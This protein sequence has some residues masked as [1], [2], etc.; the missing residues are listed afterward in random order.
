MNLVSAVLITKNE[1]V[2]LERCLASLAWADEIV[3]LDS[4]SDDATQETAKSLGATVYE[5]AW[6][7]WSQQKNHAASL[8]KHDWVFFLEA[9][10]IVSPELAHDIKRVLSSAMDSRDGYSVNRRG[11][12]LGILLPNEA[13]SSKQRAYIRLYNR[14]HSGF[15]LAAKVHEE[16]KIPGKSLALKGVLLHW[17][18]Y[19]MDEYITAFNRYATLE[20]SELA[21]QGKKATSGLVFMRPILRFLWLY[22]YKQGF[23]LGTRG[24]IHAMLKAT[25]EYIRYAKLW[26]MQN[27]SRTLHPPKGILPAYSSDSP[28]SASSGEDGSRGAASSLHSTHLE[29][30]LQ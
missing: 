9:D 17:R 22:V 12:F 24:L 20:A 25:S 4:G 5:H 13:R 3:V 23:R 7:G 1:A 2:F 21:E 15:D 28:L 18:G 10:E 30:K 11:D 27:T 14:T 6:L 8:A 26:E 16:V 19:V 29:N